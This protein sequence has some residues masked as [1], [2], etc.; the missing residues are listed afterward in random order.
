MIRSEELVDELVATLHFHN[1]LQMESSN[2][3]GGGPLNV[4]TN[5]HRKE[6]IQNYIDDLV[7]DLFFRTHNFKP[8]II[9]KD[10]KIQRITKDGIINTDGDFELSLNSPYDRY[11]FLDCLSACMIGG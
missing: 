11:T 3:F 6:S 5:D 10:L 9:P 7:I 2:I 1:Y 8:I 4:V